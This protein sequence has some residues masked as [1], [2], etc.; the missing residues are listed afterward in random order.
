VDLTDRGKTTVD[1]ERTIS[2]QV[3][4]CNAVFFASISRELVPP[5]GSRGL[6]SWH[7]AQGPWRTG[8]ALRSIA[9]CV[10]HH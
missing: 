9:G 5:V 6:I 4:Q 3:P 1:S 10:T 8:A 2:S 7:Q